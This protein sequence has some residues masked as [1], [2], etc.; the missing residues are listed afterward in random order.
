MEKDQ[1]LLTQAHYSDYPG[2]WGG[3]SSQRRGSVSSFYGV[4]QQ[5]NIRLLADS[6][7]AISD[8]YL[9]K[10]FGEELA[11]TGSTVN[12]L[13]F[14]GLVGYYRDIANRMYVRARHLNSLQGRWLSR[15]P[16]EATTARVRPYEY[17]RNRPLTEPDPTGK[18][19][20]LF[21]AI[22]CIPAGPYYELCAEACDNACTIAE[23]KDIWIR[24]NEMRERCSHPTGIWSCLGCQGK[25]AIFQDQ[26][27][28]CCNKM[29]APTQYID[30]CL[31][32]CMHWCRAN[33]PCSK[34]PGCC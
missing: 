28:Q 8:S 3:L 24:I 9:F 4:D 21:C 32:V 33:T 34:E 26:C 31:D 19:S 27:A 29:N 11:S 20:G 7:G 6:T 16:V 1:G 18:M 30:Y 12:P 14:G 15:D 17:G 2:R 10:G 13:R 5:A 22:F 25:G 23:L